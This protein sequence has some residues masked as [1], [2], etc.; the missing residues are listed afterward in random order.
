MSIR[1]PM[2]TVEKASQCIFC[3]PAPSIKNSL[4][5][6]QRRETQF[7]PTRSLWQSTQSFSGICS[8]TSGSWNCLSSSLTKTTALSTLA[9]KSHGSRNT[10]PAKCSRAAIPP[11]SRIGAALGPRLVWTKMASRSSIGSKRSRPPETQVWRALPK[12]YPQASVTSWSAQALKAPRVRP[13]KARHPRGKA[14][15]GRVRTWGL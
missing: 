14:K 2:S 3:H 9:F 1:R 12:V 6:W 8:S 4:I 5:P 11:S 15:I 7:W 13:P 10:C